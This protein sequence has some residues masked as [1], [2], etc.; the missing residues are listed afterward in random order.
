MKID[1]RTV[2]KVHA[3]TLRIVQPSRS[4]L[5]SE[6]LDDL[7]QCLQLLLALP[8]RDDHARGYRIRRIEVEFSFFFL[9]A[10]GLRHANL[11][12]EPEIVLQGQLINLRVRD[13]KAFVRIFLRDKLKLAPV[14]RQAARA[15]RLPAPRISVFVSDR[16]SKTLAL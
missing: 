13:A 12:V 16:D 6:L 1:G 5:T 8:A 10:A 4:V 14:Q 11:H 3:A 2:V 7:Q 9:V 15:D